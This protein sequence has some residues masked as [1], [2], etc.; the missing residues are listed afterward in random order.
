MGT[1]VETQKNKGD[2]AAA[3]LLLFFPYF[4]HVFFPFFLFSFFFSFWVVVLCC[5][6][7]ELV[8]R[9]ILPL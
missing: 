3:G 7:E 8:G 4:V 9:L 5:W 6:L 1:A 2:D